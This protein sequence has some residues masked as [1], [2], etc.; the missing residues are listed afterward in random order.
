MNLHAVRFFVVIVVVC[1]RGG[2]FA[3]VLG[4]GRAMSP[5]FRF[6]VYGGPGRME[7]LE[8]GVEERGQAGA[9]LTGGLSADVDELGLGDDT[10]SWF[11]GAQAYNNWVTFLVDY[12]R[13][14]LDASGTA[15][16]TFRLGVDNLAFAGLNV[17][18]LLIPVGTE[19]EIEAE[20]SWLGLGMRVTPFTL[21][22]RGR[23]RFTPWVH[24]GVQV[25]QAEYD[26][27]AGATVNL[28]SVGFPS[29]TYAERGRA[30]GDAQAAI[31]E[32]GIGGEVR[33]LLGEEPG[34]E[35]VGQLTYKLLDFQ[36]AIDALGADDDDFKDIDLEY[37]A[38][39][40]NLFLVYPLNDKADLL[41]G[42][43]VEQVEVDAVLDSRSSLGN[44]D[45][46]VDG[47]YTLYGIRAGFRF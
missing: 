40:A 37:S 12:R 21:F 10:S 19:Y 44:F 39:E 3:D 31:P 2:M 36:G 43:Y 33:I 8:G 16:Q 18:H 22:P 24:F 29:R 34:A 27:D 1:S 38:L 11:L 30:D 9:V 28:Q 42:V 46:I 25:I 6:E 26:V 14:E 20:T 15:E 45:R 13:S 23:V 4:G 32:Y 17:D 7:N 5:G 35:V 47:S 41:A